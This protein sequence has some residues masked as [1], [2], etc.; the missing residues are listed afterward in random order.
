MTLSDDQML[1]DVDRTIDVARARAETPG[2]QHRAHF[3]SCGAALMPTVVLDALREYLALEAEFGGYEAEDRRQLELSDA[4][5]ALADLINCAPEEIA[6]VDSATRAWDMGFYSLPLGPGDR[7]LTA[8]SE[9]GSNFLGMLQRTASTGASLELVP[10]ADDGSIDV[11]A[12]GGMLDERVKVVCLTHVPTDGGLVNPAAEVGRL[13]QATDVTYVLDASQSVGQMPIDVVELGC[14]VLAGPGR[15]FLRGPRGTGFLY[16]R[17][18]L[19]DAVEPPFVDVHAAEWTADRAF[20]FHSGGQR[21][22]TWESSCGAKIALGVAARYAVDWGLDAIWA[23]IR[24]ASA[25]LRA[26]LESIPGV[27]LRDRGVEPSGIVGFTLD[28]IDNA[29]ARAYLDRRGISVMTVASSYARIDMERRG[30][31]GILR[32]SVHYYNTD[33]EIERLGVA[34]RSLMSKSRSH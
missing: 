3:N 7:V 15:K 6:I 18:S 31:S 8:S 10:N 16:M 21:F 13:L 1:A 23:Q 19:A 30:L 28:G 32:A 9:Y 24:Q 17:R 29:T 27:I 2:C 14:D 11:H 26:E 22:E 33:A 20:T 12:L 5:A 25:T 34:V 4:Y